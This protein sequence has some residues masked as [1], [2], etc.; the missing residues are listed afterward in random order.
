[1]QLHSLFCSPYLQVLVLLD[2]LHLAIAVPHSYPNGQTLSVSRS[3][4]GRYLRDH[5]NRELLR[6]DSGFG[7]VFA[8]TNFYTIETEIGNQTFDLVFDTGSADM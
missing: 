1:M 4:P 8:R 5:R 3:N 2:T 7:S 6:R